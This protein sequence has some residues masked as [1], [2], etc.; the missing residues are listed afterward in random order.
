MQLRSDLGQE[1]EL[2]RGFCLLSSCEPTPGGPSSSRQ[3]TDV[4]SV[5]TT[6][7]GALGCLDGTGCG[8]SPLEE[9]GQC[10]GCSLLCSDSQLPLP[11]VPGGGTQPA[12]PAMDRWYL[13]GSPKGDVDPFYYDYETVRNGGLIFAALAFLVGLLILL[14]KRLRC[15]AKKQHRQVNEDEL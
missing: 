3:F 13:G 1:S 7:R 15:G 11:Q 2:S 8:T 9:R 4:I 14:G 12:A 5:P 10:G 6:L